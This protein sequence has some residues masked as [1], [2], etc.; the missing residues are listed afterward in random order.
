[1]MNGKTQYWENNVPE[2]LSE[3][4]IEAIIKE[5]ENWNCSYP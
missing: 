1:M 3:Y 4:A 2:D 5:V